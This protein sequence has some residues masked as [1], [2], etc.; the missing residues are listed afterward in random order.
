MI[1]EK[2]EEVECEKS[3]D[4]PTQLSSDLTQITERLLSL[5]VFE[6][7]IKFH[8]TECLHPSV[9]LVTIIDITICPGYSSIEEGVIIASDGMDLMDFRII[10]IVCIY[11][12]THPLQT[13]LWDH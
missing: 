8:C 11:I 1:L 5:S 13:P 3:L 6:A 4:P 10:W 9:L 7:R 2:S 12:Y